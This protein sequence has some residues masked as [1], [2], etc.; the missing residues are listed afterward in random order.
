METVFSHLSLG[1]SAL[2]GVAAA[3]H[4]FG[5]APLS[6]AYRRWQYPLGFREVTGALLALASVLLAFHAT[7]ILGIVVA[8]VVMFLTAT[9]LLHHRQYGYAM[10]LIALLFAL[11]PI[12]LSGPV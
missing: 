1:L 10:P 8:A 4:L 7:R 3:A 9:T 11:V 5:F 2:F 12:S 6:D